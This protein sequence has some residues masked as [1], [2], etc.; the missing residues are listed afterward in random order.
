MEREPA[1]PDECGGTPRVHDDQES[2]DRRN[3][4]EYQGKP[5]P[6]VPLRRPPVRVR[7]RCSEK[8]Q[9]GAHHVAVEVAIEE[10]E[11]GKFRDEVPLILARGPHV[12]HPAGE[13]VIEI[14]WSRRETSHF[15]IGDGSE[16]RSDPVRK[17]PDEEPDW[18]RKVTRY[19][20]E[21][22]REGRAPPVRTADA[23]TDRPGQS[24]GRRHVGSVVPGQCEVVRVFNPCVGEIG[25]QCGEHVPAVIILDGFVREPDVFGGQTPS[26]QQRS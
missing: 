21:K 16:T 24:P 17:C 10:S 11:K 18:C 13:P 26:S 23:G 5:P 8:Q 19:R 20:D 9:R 22:R 4:Q 3:R 12:Y 14:H 15:Q 25:E 7:E 1:N 2:H 6:G